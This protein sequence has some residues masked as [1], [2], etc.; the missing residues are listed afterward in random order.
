MNWNFLNYSCLSEPHPIYKFNKPKYFQL[1]K[2]YSIKLSK[3]FKFVR[4]DLYELENEIRLGELTFI[5]MNSFFF[6]KTKK[7]K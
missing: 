4:I 6:V 3:N 5:P 1:M 7:M 2:D